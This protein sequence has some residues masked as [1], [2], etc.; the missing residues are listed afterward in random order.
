MLAFVVLL[1]T[2]LLVVLFVF[3][4]GT[5]LKPGVM[6]KVKT[7]LTHFQV[8]CLCSSQI[9]AVHVNVQQLPINMMHATFT[10]L[11]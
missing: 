9:A 10:K 4:F 6:I 5:D 7:L 2:A 3:D 8:G 1:F 11:S